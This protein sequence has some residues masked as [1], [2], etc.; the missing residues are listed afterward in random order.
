ME[1]T[2]TWTAIRKDRAVPA[3]HGGATLAL[4]SLR[5]LCGTTKQRS[6]VS[7]MGAFVGVPSTYVTDQESNPPRE[8]S[9]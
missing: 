2:T 9:G 6:L 3:A 5:A 4:R 8:E 7:P 1:I